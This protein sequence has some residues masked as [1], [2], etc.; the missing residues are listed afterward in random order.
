MLPRRLVLLVLAALPAAVGFAAY[1]EETLANGLRVVL[2]EHHA[3]PM[4]A[5]TVVVGAGVT[6]ERPDRSGASHLLEHLLFNGTTTRSQRALYDATDR[7]GAYNNATTR[8]DHTLFTLLV[9]REF[10][11]E[12]LDLQADMLFRSTIPAENFDKEKGIVLE[13]MARDASDPGYAAAQGFRSFAYAGTPLAR[14]VLGTPESIAAIRRD[15]VVAYWRE[16]YVPRNMLLV[17]MGDFETPAM[18]ETVRRTFGGAPAGSAQA[19]TAGAW[20]AAPRENLSL[21]KLDAPR[22]YVEA[23]FPLGLAAHDPL[24]PAVELLLDALAAGEDAPLHEALGSG[25]LGL[26]PRAGPWTTVELEATL[27][28]GKPYTP[29]LDALARGLSDLGPGSP[30]RARLELVRAAARAREILEADQIHYFALNRG[31]ALLQA[32]PG[33]LARSGRRYDGILDEELDR[34]AALLREGLKA[35]RVAV[36]GPEIADG[37]ARWEPKVAV[38][39]PARGRVDRVFPNGVRA[40]AEAS[41]DSAVCAIHVALRPRAAS[42]PPDRPGMASLLHHMLPRG[43]TQLDEAAL[44]ARLARLGATL[45]TDDDPSVPYDDYS[46]TPEFSFVRMELPADGWREGIALLGDLLVHPRLDER[47][48]AAVVDEMRDLQARRDAASR[49]RAMDA[50]EAALAPGHPLTRPVLGSARSLQG[51]TVGDLRTF[52]Q[53]YVTGR[54]LVVT[55]ES[56]VAPEAVLEALH[57]AFGSLPEGSP[58]P[59]VPPPP[60]TAGGGSERRAAAPAEQVTIAMGYVFEAPEADRAALAVLGA[61]LSD[62]LA[63]DLRETRGLAYSIGASIA[64]WGGR[65][66]LL[67]TMGTRKANL[68]EAIAGLRAGI[69]GFSPGDRAAVARAAASLRGRMLMRRLTR[70]NQAYF[71][72]MEA[73][74][75][76]PLGRERER[77]DALLRVDRDAVAAAVRTYLDAAKCVLVVE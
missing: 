67:V 43:T 18:L 61:L 3:N 10:A 50:L 47:D 77:L 8:E 48:L 5:S 12:G 71:L 66:R 59:A 49:N 55:V 76:Q 74:A 44:A 34:A 39:P 25:T 65:M 64:P 63:F 30:A 57:D 26:A 24:V 38:P 16:R 62:A 70:I 75:G 36:L 46:T 9:Q 29:V 2:I 72:A 60:V 69:A 35:A 52:H 33:W 45:K 51:V 19:S 7:A 15:E 21:Q 11:E 42:E 53:A 22:T 1:R 14:P 28:P 73:L 68:E 27:A 56:P 41:D 31:A 32:P 6:E 17:V 58:L 4:V 20:P 40:I 23:G 37:T 13:E 54:H